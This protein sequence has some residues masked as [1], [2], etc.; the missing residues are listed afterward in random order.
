M[1]TMIGAFE[2]KTHLSELL[3]RVEAGQEIT[4]SKH[5]RPVARLVPFDEPPAD[6]DWQEFWHRVDSTLVTPTPGTSIK[7]DIEAGRR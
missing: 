4:I 1:T 7:G 2:A 3:Q 5:G 6:R